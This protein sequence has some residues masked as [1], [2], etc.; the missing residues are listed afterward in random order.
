MPRSNVFR[1]IAI[2]ALLVTA[3][4]MAVALPYAVSRPGESWFVTR[5]AEVPS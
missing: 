2:M 4:I 5:I 3:M 1:I